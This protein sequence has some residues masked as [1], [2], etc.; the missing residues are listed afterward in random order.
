MCTV[1]NF[2]FVYL[3]IQP[4]GMLPPPP[5]IKPAVMSSSEGESEEE[6]AVIAP[7]N[8]EGE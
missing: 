1:S 4:F 2:V 6:G 8:R 5:P 7:E 3:C